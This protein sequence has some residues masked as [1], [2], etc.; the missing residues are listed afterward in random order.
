MVANFEMWERE[1]DLRRD[2]QNEE[3]KSKI[4]KLSAFIDGFHKRSQLML[5]SL[6][7]NNPAHLDSANKM[8]GQL[9][10]LELVAK[11]MEQLFKVTVLTEPRE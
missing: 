10:A 5:N 8:E 3:L 4:H 2:N 9:R 1:Q 6:D 11:H 7:T